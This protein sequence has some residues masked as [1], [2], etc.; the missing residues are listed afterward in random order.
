MKKLVIFLVFI[1]LTNCSTDD[2]ATIDI[3]DFSGTTY[4]PVD[5]PFIFVYDEN[6]ELYLET[7][8]AD[9]I[10]V[11]LGDNTSLGDGVINNQVPTNK[12]ETVTDLN[13]SG[14]QISNLSAIRGFLALETLNCSDNNLVSLD[15]SSNEE[16]RELN[17][18]NNNVS[19]FVSEGAD[20]L[21][22]LSGRN[23][24]LS[25][26]YLT[27]HSNLEIIDVSHN[28]LTNLSLSFINQL[29][30][31]NCSNNQ[32]QVMTFGNV[33]SIEFI[34]CSNNN[35]EILNLS[36][37]NNSQLLF[38]NAMDNPNLNCIEIDSDFTPPD[39]QIQQNNESGWCI[40]NTTMYSIDCS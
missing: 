24:S 7:H 15:I 16:L 5:L 18:D 26:I 35:L 25:T 10:E 36:N 14:L 33:P 30:N 9:G 22:N 23:N 11:T 37:N 6:F 31:V 12:I 4:P 2:N 19:N 8:N 20:L 38:M 21:V 17:F 29:R 3:F 39:C 13:I 27:I 34:N 40:D 28:M 32:I 1:S